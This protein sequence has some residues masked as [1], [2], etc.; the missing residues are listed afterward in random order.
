M[1]APHHRAHDRRPDGNHADGN[2]A[3]GNHGIGEQLDELCTV[4]ELAALLRVPEAT[5]R[6][7]IHCGTGPA[8]FKIGRHVR[9]RRDDINAWLNRQRRAGAGD[10]AEFD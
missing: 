3:D 7:W 4:A 2:H 1:S 9:Y 10:H 8:S 6:Y 5:I